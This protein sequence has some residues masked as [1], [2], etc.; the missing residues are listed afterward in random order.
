MMKVTMASA[1]I[2]FIRSKEKRKKMRQ[3]IKYEDIPEGS[4]LDQITIM[5]QVCDI[6]NWTV[7]HHG[8]VSDNFISFYS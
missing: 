5:K 7:S 4:L 2:E 1:G 3:M 8:N 6:S